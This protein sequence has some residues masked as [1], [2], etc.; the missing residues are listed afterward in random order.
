[1]VT[2][3]LGGDAKLAKVVDTEKVLILAS[4]YESPGIAAA[5][6]VRK[7]P[8]NGAF[9]RKDRFGRGRSKEKSPHPEKE[10]SIKWRR[11]ACDWPQ[12]PG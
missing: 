7:K 2:E 12:S 8:N 11:R 3:Q 1:V 9:G 10:K 6:W 4:T 5:G